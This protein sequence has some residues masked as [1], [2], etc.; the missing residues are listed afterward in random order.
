[1]LVVYFY[2]AKAFTQL[3]NPQLAPTD[4]LQL[5]KFKGCR[6]CDIAD[7]E[8]DY[9][10]WLE[11]NGYVHYSKETIALIHKHARFQEAERHRREEVNPYIS[12]DYVCRQER[13]IER[14]Y[15]A[16]GGGYVNYGGPCGP[17]YFDRDGNI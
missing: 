5:G 13:E 17:L 10:I 14:V 3:K 8:Y 2:M 7:T 6:V 12:Q 4:K 11:R 15:Y 16:D 9:L 1:M